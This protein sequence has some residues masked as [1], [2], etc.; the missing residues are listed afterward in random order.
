[1]YLFHSDFCFG[2]R[3]VIGAAP[4]AAV[5]SDIV[6]KMQWNSKS[7]GYGVPIT[8]R[9]RQLW[10][11]MSRWSRVEY[12]DH[13]KKWIIYRIWSSRLTGARINIAKA[14]GV[15]HL[16]GTLC[17]DAKHNLTPGRRRIDILIGF[18][19]DT[20]VRK[21]TMWPGMIENMNIHWGIQA[22]QISKGYNSK[23]STQYDDT[24]NG[25]SFDKRWT[26][27]ITWLS[28][29]LDGSMCWRGRMSP[30]VTLIEAARFFR[31]FLSEFTW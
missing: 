6:W 20:T 28:G 12:F 30:R 8:D 9:K 26:F 27:W 14:S 24:I 15:V 22:F 31:T 25:G 3:Y 18:T 13:M 2:D 11:K 16:H 1:M 4:S 23:D 5:M 21:C 19:L 17:N 10:W 29:R 7:T